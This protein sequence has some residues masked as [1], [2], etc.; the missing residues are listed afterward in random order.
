MK[1]RFVGRVPA[2]LGHDIEK[3]EIHRRRVCLTLT[4]PSGRTEHVAD[5]VIAATGYQVDVRRL[6]FLGEEILSGIR[7]MAQAPVLSPYFE[8]SIPGLYV[9]G[10]ASKYCFGPVMQFSCGASWTATRISRRLAN[11]RLRTQ[12]APVIAFDDVVSR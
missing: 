6:S 4:G 1:E 3:A 8:T 7:V 10:I 9:V 11:A 12:R 2:L 5:H